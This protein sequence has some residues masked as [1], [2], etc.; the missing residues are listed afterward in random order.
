[1]NSFL[2][3]MPS[4]NEAPQDTLNLT[5]DLSNDLIELGNDR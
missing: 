5:N 1:M 4:I 3:D 2:P